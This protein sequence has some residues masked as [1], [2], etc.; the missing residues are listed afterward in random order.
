MAEK[1]RDLTKIRMILAYMNDYNIETRRIFPE[2]VA[3][4]GFSHD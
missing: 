2:Y 3:A 4:I 1:N